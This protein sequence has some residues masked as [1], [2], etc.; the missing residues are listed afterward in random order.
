VRTAGPIWLSPGYENGAFY[1]SHCHTQR[2]HRDALERSKAHPLQAADTPLGGDVE[3]HQS[4][5]DPPAAVCPVCQQPATIADH[6]PGATWILV[7]GCPCGGFV[8]AANTLEWRLPALT[9]PQRAELSETIRGFRAMS[10]EAWLTTA[11][12]GISGQLVLRPKRA[13]G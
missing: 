9:A 13:D 3:P 4:D 12:G 11:D 7:E 10:R 1:H 5:A 2:F 8:V 6:A